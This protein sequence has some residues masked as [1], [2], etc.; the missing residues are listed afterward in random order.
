[1][2]GFSDTKFNKALMKLLLSVLFTIVKVFFQPHPVWRLLQSVC[3]GF[4]CHASLS[5]LLPCY[6]WLF[7]RHKNFH[8]SKEKLNLFRLNERNFFSSNSLSIFSIVFTTSCVFPS[9]F[10]YSIYQKTQTN[11]C[12]SSCHMNF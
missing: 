12:C 7:S 3:I 1:M 8:I 4:S 5:Q 2:L 9:L 6:L 11:F 10:A